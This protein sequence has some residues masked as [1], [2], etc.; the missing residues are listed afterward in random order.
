MPRTLEFEIV[1]LREETFAFV[2]RRVEPDEADEFIHGA[3]ERVAGFA[4]AF[5]GIQGRRP[6]HHTPPDELGARIVE[7]GW[8]VAASAVSDGAVEVRTLHATPALV[9]FTS[10][11]ARSSAA[12]STPNCSRTLTNMVCGPNRGR[13]S[14]TSTILRVT[15]SR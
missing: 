10:G 14:A 7:A 15:R 5:G 2:V 13:A 8:P 9:T 1:D 6:D 12:G 4:A 3:L 11:R